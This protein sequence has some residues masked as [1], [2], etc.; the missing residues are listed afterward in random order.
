ML[1]ALI[2]SSRDTNKWL[3]ETHTTISQDQIALGVD[4][5]RTSSI[6][7]R[8]RSWSG[9]VSGRKSPRK[10]LLKNKK[11]WTKKKHANG[12]MTG[13]FKRRNSFRSFHRI[14]KEHNKPRYKTPHN[15]EHRIFSNSRNTIESYDSDFQVNLRH[16]RY[17]TTK[18]KEPN[19]LHQTVRNLPPY[20]QM[21]PAY[22]SPP[23]ILSPLSPSYRPR[24]DASKAISRG[25]SVV[26]HSSQVPNAYSC[27]P[28]YRPN[29]FSN[30][31]ETVY[32]R[33][34]HSPLYAPRVEAV[35]STYIP[36]NPSITF[37]EEGMSPP[38]TSKRKM[39]DENTFMNNNDPILMNNHELIPQNKKARIQIET[40]QT[41]QSKH[42]AV[43]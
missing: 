1:G 10:T 26:G 14:Q 37:E 18:Q 33:S 4:R 25:T 15:N 28:T 8:H 41:L 24:F 12:G 5:N 6:D 17:I 7:N 42:Q 31:A 30:S 39:N 22:K 3:D 36:S 38:Y 9:N 21:V 27:S 32:Y 35:S 29:E 19:L 2:R 34:P 13:V 40:C 16:N 20:K 43:S 11:H 23:P